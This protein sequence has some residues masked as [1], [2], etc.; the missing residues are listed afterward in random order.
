SARASTRHGSERR[1][2][3]VLLPAPSAST[4]AERRSRMTRQP[5]LRAHAVMRRLLIGGAASFILRPCACLAF[6]RTSPKIVRIDPPKH[7]LFVGNSFVYYNNGLP[8]HLA[9]LIVS[10]DKASRGQ[11]TFKSLTISGAYLSDH[12]DGV[13]PVLKSRKWDVVVLQ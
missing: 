1:W 6:A 12:I 3:L 10:A 13:A 9:R 7:I 4:F 2:R 8:D 11:Y 5:S